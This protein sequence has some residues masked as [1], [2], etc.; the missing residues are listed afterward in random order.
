MACRGAGR[1]IGRCQHAL[2]EQLPTRLFVDVGR[3]RESKSTRLGVAG[4]G[5]DAPVVEPRCDG[6]GR[7]R[8]RRRGLDGRATD[9]AAPGR[10][11]GGRHGRVRGVDD[12]HAVGTHAAGCRRR[13]VDGVGA[14]EAVSLQSL[15]GRR[16]HAGVA[17]RH[18]KRLSVLARQ[19]VV[20]YRVHR[21]THEVQHACRT[22]TTSAARIA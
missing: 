21:R 8:S 16:V 13:V 20:Q 6:H 17:Q 4:S 12:R 3:V 22:S 19:H 2:I 5:G 15:A 10:R 18:D 14:G 1:S 7:E 9:G 11:G